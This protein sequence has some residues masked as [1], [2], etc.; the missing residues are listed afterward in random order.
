MISD[1]KY[2]HCA[3]LLQNSTYAVLQ[4][5]RIGCCNREMTHFENTFLDM[6]SILGKSSISLAFLCTTCA[7]KLDEALEYY[8]DNQASQSSMI[9]LPEKQSKL[10][11]KLAVV[12][13]KLHEIKEELT[14][15]LSK[16]CEMLSAPEVTKTSP[17]PA[18]IANT[19]FT[20]INEE[21]DREKRQ[22]NLIVHNLAESPSD[23][24]EI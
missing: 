16:C 21:R 10:E 2:N 17:G 19:V 20:A 1:N 4:I 5:N 23:R 15:Q 11:N 9:N 18:L 7:P 12:E 14:N 6:C 3:L 13:S 8:D 24:G 22:L